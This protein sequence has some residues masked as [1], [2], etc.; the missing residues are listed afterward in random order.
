VELGEAALIARQRTALARRAPPG[1]VGIHL[2]VHHGVPGQCLAHPLRAERA[3]A[4][5]HDARVVPRQQLEHQLLLARAKG[6]LALPVE[7]R[8]ERLPESPLELAV[9][10]E[11]LG[12]ELGGKGAGAGGLPGPH[13]ADEHDGYGRLQPMRS[14]YARSAAVTSSMWSPPSFSR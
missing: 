7:E 6:L 4:E 13:E 5:R 8:L 11:R 3:A 12:A 14:S 10:V 1:L 9:R 2:Q